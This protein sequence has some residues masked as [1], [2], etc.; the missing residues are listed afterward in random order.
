[1]NSLQAFKLNFQSIYRNHD[2]AQTCAI[3]MI[4]FGVKQFQSTFKYQNFNNLK[5]LCEKGRFDPADTKLIQDFIFNE[6]TDNIKLGIC[7]ENLLKAILLSNL[8]LVH[9]IDHNKFKELSKRQ[10]K[11]PIFVD[12]L[13]KISPYFSNHNI[14][15]DDES[16]KEQ[17]KGLKEQTINYSILIGSERYLN[18]F[19]VPPKLISILRAEN[20]KRN[21]LHMYNHASFE[22]NKKTF[23][24]FEFVNNFLKK[25]IPNWQKELF[26]NLKISPENRKLSMIIRK[27]TPNKV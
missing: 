5:E 26:K 21:K 16:V 20:E 12:E 3:N 27:T 22:F 17:I 11:E 9:N 24:D 25:N 10:K 7:F 8:Y 13:L 4:D 15:T 14:D 19:N 6:L 23:E 1:M 2:N 18:H